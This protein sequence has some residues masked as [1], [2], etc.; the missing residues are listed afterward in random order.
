MLRDDRELGERLGPGAREFA[1]ER[2]SW[3][4]NAAALADFYRVRLDSARV[5]AAA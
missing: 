5:P 1:V 2:L 3:P 4:R